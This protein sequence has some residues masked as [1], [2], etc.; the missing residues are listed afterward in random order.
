MK[1]TLTSLIIYFICSFNLVARPAEVTIY[2]IKSVMSPSHG[3]AQ[4]L[5]EKFERKHQATLKYVVFNSSADL[6]L[7]LKIEGEK[8]KADVVLGLDYYQL[9][10]AKDLGIFEDYPPELLTDLTLPVAW[11]EGELFPYEY[12]YLGFLYKVAE[13]PDPPKSF[14]ELLRAPDVRL[15]IPAPYT[16]IPGFGLVLWVKEIFAAQAPKV[17]RQ[18]RPKIVATTKSWSQAYAL[19]HKGEANMV[20]SYTNDA[21]H[22]AHVGQKGMAMALFEEGHF[23]QSTLMG[24]VRGSGLGALGVEVMKLMLTPDMQKRIANKSWMY[25]VVS[26]DLPTSYPPIEITRTIH[27]KVAAMNRS[28]WAKEWRSALSKLPA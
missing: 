13:L 16:S 21:L 5:S 4:E 23:F 19:F 12:G 27:P 17:W 14:E 18:L 8:T 9:E 24:V 1:R 7:R 11:G 2:T 10:E 28:A 22:M 26:T 20:L 6:L 15:V 3:F 25:P